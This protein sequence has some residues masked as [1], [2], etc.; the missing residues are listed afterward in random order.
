MYDNTLHD[1]DH[2]ELTETIERANINLITEAAASIPRNETMSDNQ[3]SLM[4]T[5]SC[6]IWQLLK[7]PKNYVASQHYIMIGFC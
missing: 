3:M 2:L 7:S 5:V 4:D 6:I 1:K